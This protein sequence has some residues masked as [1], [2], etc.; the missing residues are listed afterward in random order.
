[1]TAEIMHLDIDQLEL[2]RRYVKTVIVNPRVSPPASCPMIVKYIVQVTSNLYSVKIKRCDGKKFTRPKGPALRYLSIHV[3]AQG[4]SPYYNLPIF[5]PDE[6]PKQNEEPEREPI[7]R[8]LCETGPVMNGPYG[9]LREQRSDLS[10]SLYS[11]PAHCPWCGALKCFG[12]MC[13]RN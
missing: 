4:I 5:F 1:M 8:R 13:P 9:T 10:R 12:C 7:R 3:N 11:P 6:V 2:A